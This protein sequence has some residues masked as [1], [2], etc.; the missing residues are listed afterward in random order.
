MAT[1]NH[2]FTELRS[3]LVLNRSSL[4]L[5]CKMASLSCFLVTVLLAILYIALPSCS[6][7]RYPVSSYAVVSINPQ[8]DFSNL[9]YWSAHPYKWDPSDSLPKP[10]RNDQRDTTADVF[11]IYPTTY[12]NK[13]K[14]A[15][16]PNGGS[17]WNADVNDDSLNAKTDYSAT[18]NQVSAFNHYRV[19]APRYRQAHYQSFFIADSISRPFFETAYADVKT[20]FEY[21]MA[22]NNNGRPFIIA[23]H[24]QGT[25]HAARLIKELIENKPLAKKMIAAYLVGMPIRTDYFTTI[26][27]CD[28]ADK[29]GCFVSWRTYKEGYFSPYVANETFKAS[30]VNPL[31]W[32]MDE[33]TASRKL[34][35]GTILFKFNKIKKYNLNARVSGNVLWS[36]KPRFLGNVFLKEKNYHIGDINFFWKNI[37][38]NVQTRV[39]K[40]MSNK[41]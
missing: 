33:E 16:Q 6:E 34:N 21:Y 15:S 36:S 37:R 26:L 28:N 10:Y 35:N 19:F 18:L 31:S 40:F 3:R 38:D 24:S 7:M 4:G 25:V 12:T 1:V 27:P 30:V 14:I 2:V 32:K 9:Y 5:F 23:S 8:P 22:H 11:F 20:A 29:T 39:E 17:L 41:L 13:V